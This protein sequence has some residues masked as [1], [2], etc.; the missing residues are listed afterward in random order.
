MNS[1][2]NSL[3]ATMLASL[4]ATGAVAQSVKLND[5]AASADRATPFAT[6]QDNLEDALT[7][8]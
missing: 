4:Y 2:R 6:L 8:G 7:A 1:N 5:A 3:L